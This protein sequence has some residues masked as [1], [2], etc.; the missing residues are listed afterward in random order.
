MVPVDGEGVDVTLFGRVI[1][2]WTSCPTTGR[3][4][5][6][7]A[8]PLVVLAASTAARSSAQGALL[9]A[10]GLALLI[11]ALVDR[12][13]FRLPNGLVAMA[14][15]AAPLAAVSAS[16]SG[17]GAAPLAGALAGGAIC[18]AAML[19]IHLRRGV[20]M[21]DVK[22]SAVIGMGCGSVAVIAAP[23]AL[24]IAATIAALT[25]SIT[26]RQ[27]LAMGPSFVAGW[28]CALA[29]AGWWSA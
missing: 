18:G 6:V 1:R 19:G 17:L 26:R 16:A 13:E 24:V 25:G 10:S 11:A 8:V 23:V 14:A 20:G 5:F 2:S 27:R 12:H 9:A 29:S 4:M 3:W 15:V 7:G 28:V 21:G 22:T